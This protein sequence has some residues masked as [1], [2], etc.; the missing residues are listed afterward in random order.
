[1][2]R[3]TENFVLNLLNKLKTDI[4]IILVTHRIK[5]ARFSNRIYILENGHI[6]AQGQHEELMETENLY[7]LSYNELVTNG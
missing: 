7:S 4:C 3:N 2:D 5:I 1:M 6:N